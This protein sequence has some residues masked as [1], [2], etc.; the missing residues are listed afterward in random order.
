MPCSRTRRIACLRHTSTLLCSL[1]T[2]HQKCPWAR[3]RYTRLCS[4]MIGQMPPTTIT[5]PPCR[6]TKCSLV[7]YNILTRF[8]VVESLNPSKLFSLVSVC[9][10]SSSHR[11][12]PHRRHCYRLFSCRTL[13]GPPPFSLSPNLGLSRT[14]QM[15]IIHQH[16]CSR[17][18]PSNVI[19]SP[20][21]S[22]SRVPLLLERKL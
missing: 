18:P 16:F 11:P 14:L 1:L 4:R 3:C 15:H 12:V 10:C 21:F 5:K 6:P 7:R 9:G 8:S 19:S 17:S 20:L 2:N 13:T 22:S